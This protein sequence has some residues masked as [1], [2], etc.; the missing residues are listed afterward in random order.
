MPGIAAWAIG[1]AASSHELDDFMLLSLRGCLQ[2]TVI[3]ALIENYLAVS[4]S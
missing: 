3:D 4:N 1:K 2:Y